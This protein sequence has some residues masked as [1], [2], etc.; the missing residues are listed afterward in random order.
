MLQNSCYFLL[1]GILL[2]S[3]GFHV[4]TVV[5]FVCLEVYFFA[6]GIFHCPQFVHYAQGIILLIVF[7]CFFLHN[8]SFRTE[9]LKHF[10]LEDGHAHLILNMVDRSR[11]SGDIQLD[12]DIKDMLQSN[13]CVT[14]RS[15]EQYDG[16]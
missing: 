4:V 3:E 15:S 9:F 7:F 2:I 13:D 16:R 14:T 11:L 6:S 10:S 1:I 8:E 5:L 12:S